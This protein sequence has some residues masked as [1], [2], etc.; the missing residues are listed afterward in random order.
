MRTVPCTLHRLEIKGKTVDF[1]AADAPQRPSRRSTPGVPL[2]D[3]S[4]AVV[5]RADVSGTGF[6]CYVEDADAKQNTIAHVQLRNQAGNG[7][8][9]DDLTF[10][11][12]AT[13]AD[14]SRSF[15]QV[16][17]EQPG[18]VAWPITGATFILGA[19]HAGCDPKAVA[20][21]ERA[22]AWTTT[23]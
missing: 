3:A 18:K 15:H 13:G 6:L 22:R 14:W 17:T 7:V 1:G 10:K 23:S 9:P 4:I 20:T 16:L 11:A 2:P 12:A 19:T 5:R 8:A 21:S